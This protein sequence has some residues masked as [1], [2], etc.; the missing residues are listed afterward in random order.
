MNPWKRFHN[1]FK[2]LLEEEDRIVRQRELRDRLNGTVIYQESGEFG[3][4]SLAGGATESLKA[5][6]ELLATEAGIALGSPPGIVPHVYWLDGLFVD[7]RENKSQHIRIY[8]LDDA[9][10]GVI[11]RLLEASATYCAR[12]DRR[13]LEYAAMSCEDPRLER[14]AAAD[15]H[16]EVNAGACESPQSELSGGRLSDAKNAVMPAPGL[17]ISTTDLGADRTKMVDDFLVQCNRESAVGLRVIRKHIWLAVGHARARQFQYWQERSDKATDADDRAF[18]RILC[19]PPSK[20]ICGSK[21]LGSWASRISRS[22]CA[23]NGRRRRSKP[24]G[25]SS[26]ARLRGPIGTMISWRWSCRTSRHRT[27]ISP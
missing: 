23:T 6:F 19:M 5:R 18:R 13:S 1:E 17:T 11:E 7:L 20:F 2:A 8:N 24:S 4:W 22:S 26:T 14:S 21:P 27:S 10:G 12:L 16:T 25:S 15:L 9:A 3:S